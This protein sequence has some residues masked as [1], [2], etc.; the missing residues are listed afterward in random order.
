MAK[1]WANRGFD[2]PP[3]YGNYGGGGDGGTKTF[4][5]FIPAPDPEHPQ[6]YTKR[7]L[8][9]DTVPFAF[10]EHNFYKITGKS[11]DK[12]ICIGRSGIDKRGCP[13]CEQEF[14]PRYVGYF[15]V[16]DLGTVVRQGGKVR[17]EGYRGKKDRVWQF[18]KKLLCA[19]RGG[20]DKPGVLKKLERYRERHG[21]DLTGTVWDVTRT[22]KKVEACGDEWDFVERV[23]PEEF[24]E[25][26]VRWGADRSKL[27][28]TPVDY[29]EEFV[30]RSYEDLARVIGRSG[31][32]RRDG[33]GRGDGEKRVDGAG[34]DDGG[35]PPG[36]DDIPF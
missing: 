31:D 15:T 1:D 11:Q 8:F 33:P 21:G 26:L 19:G 29:Y 3:D 35:Q 32:P 10:W 17:L 12:A 7:I 18:D 24:A 30:P 25:Y 20:D 5:F 27:E 34:Y 28:L 22:G 9:L 16:I 6:G 2:D 13:L 4:G 36:D 14:W 23:K